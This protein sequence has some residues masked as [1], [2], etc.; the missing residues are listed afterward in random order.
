MNAKTLTLLILVVG[1]LTSCNP[2]SGNTPSSFEQQFLGTW[3]LKRK[4]VND[5]SNVHVET[6]T[7]TAH[8]KVVF[9]SD[10]LG[11]SSY[12]C[13]DGIYDCSPS[14]S[15]WSAASPYITMSGYQ[16][17]IMNQSNTSLTLRDYSNDETIFQLEKNY[18]DLYTTCTFT[19]SIEFN[20]P[21]PLGHNGNRLFLNYIDNNGLSQTA[22][23]TGLTTWSQTV[24]QD[25]S[26]A[27]HPYSYNIS[28]GSDPNVDNGG[29]NW[30][31]L[32]T[33]KITDG[34]GTVIGQVGPSYL[35]LED[36]NNS[37]NCGGATEP[38]HFNIQFDCTN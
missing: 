14:L 12:S 26:Q 38:Q 6:S 28:L 27:Y 36:Y 2:N 11:V 15:T 19:Y 13:S 33:L 29:V 22:D 5:P 16:Y 37:Q 21:I 3:Y 32:T 34:D 23:L 30:S 8:C 18:S 35:C 25:F 20:D 1:S 24:T 7:D 10:P 31:T 17:Q 4:T 9:K